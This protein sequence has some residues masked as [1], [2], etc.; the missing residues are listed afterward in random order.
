MSAVES[1]HHGDVVIILPG[2]YSVS[3]SIFIPDSITIEGTKAPP[4]LGEVGGA[5]AVS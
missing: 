5:R 4:T 3:S 2:N 1:C